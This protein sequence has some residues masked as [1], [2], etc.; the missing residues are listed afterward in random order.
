MS[1]ETYLKSGM[2]AV[3][4]AAMEQQCVTAAWLRPLLQRSIPEK[5]VSAVYTVSRL[6]RVR[7]VPM[8]SMASRGL[9][10]RWTR[11]SKD[12]TWSPRSVCVPK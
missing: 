6:S 12:L 10:R 9:G 11:V 1:K 7:T 2:C 4:H 8:V 5:R 3:T